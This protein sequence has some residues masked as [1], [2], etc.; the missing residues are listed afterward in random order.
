MLSIFLV[1]NTQLRMVEHC[2]H[3]CSMKTIDKSIC[4]SRLYS[5]THA[6]VQSQYSRVH[7]SKV[8]FAGHAFVINI[9]FVWIT[10]SLFF[11]SVEC[12]F[13]PPFVYSLKS[14]PYQLAVFMQRIS[15]HTCMCVC[16]RHSRPEITLSLFCKFAQ[17]GPQ[18]ISCELRTPIKRTI[19]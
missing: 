6:H 4:W 13:S 11:Q 12:F 9:T 2:G 14:C 8:W 5:H 16:V 3:S 10:L 17:F 18:A 1:P 19:H 15:L 7:E